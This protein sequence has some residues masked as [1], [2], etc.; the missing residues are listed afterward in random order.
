[1]QWIDVRLSPDRTSLPLPPGFREDL[2]R[3][4]NLSIALGACWLIAVLAAPAASQDVVKVGGVFALGHPLF[5]V[6]G[7]EELLGWEDALGIANEEGGINGK[8]IVWVTEDGKY[9]ATVGIVK[10]RELM[11]KHK[12]LVALGDSTAL[13]K[14]LAPEINARYRVLYG[15]PSF[16]AELAQAEINPYM[17]LAGPT[18]AD[19]FEILLRYIAREKPDATVAFFYSDTEWGKDPIAYG[20]QVCRRLRLELV[21]EKIWT[22]GTKDLSA[23]I[24][25]LKKRDPDYMIFQG[26]LCDPIPE[27][28][29]N[30]KRLGLKC[31]FMGTF[32]SATKMVLEQLGPLAEGYMVVN[33][34]MY[35]WY[36][37]V[38][39]IRKIRD[40]RARKY[41]DH[42]YRDNFYMQM[43]MNGLIAVECLR[44]ADKAGELNSQGL[45]EA[46]RSLVDFDTGGLCPPMTIRNNRFPVGRVW[47]VN[48]EKKIYE[49]ISDWMLLD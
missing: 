39:M 24:Q 36:K 17:F 11:K 43:F 8:K 18:Y 38:P 7:R 13:G 45:V 29:R 21:A 41:N 37:D 5:G 33:P 22:P 14:A 32:W 47:R 23:M 27:V 31:R 1:M 19:Q 25:D 30:F 2:V 15:S 28:I 9:D 48:V 16:S 12:P 10:F 6:A 42:T 49:P 34:Y 35:W 4:K 40:Y 20:R 3:F 26:V 46:L 44:R